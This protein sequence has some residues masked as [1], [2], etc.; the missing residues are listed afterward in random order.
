[1]QH[2]WQ[3]SEIIAEL[4]VNIM[5]YTITVKPYL[6][7]KS[8]IIINEQLA[9]KLNLKRKKHGYAA[10][11]IRKNYVDVVIKKYLPENVV[12]LSERVIEHLNMPLFPVFEIKT[13]G[14]EIGF[15]PCIGIL[16]GQKDE[17][18]TKRRLKKMTM[19]TLDYKRIHGAI[20]VFALDK[21]DKIKQLIEGYCYKHETDSWERGIFPYPSVIYRRTELNDEWK[22]YFLSVIGDTVFSNHSFDKWDMYKWFSSEPDINPHLPV[23]LVYKSNND[24]IEMLERYRVIYVKPISGMK[25]FGVVKVSKEEKTITFRYR[26]DDKNIELITSNKK[27]LEETIEKLFECKEYIIQQGLDLMNFDGGIVDFRCVMQKNEAC[28]WICNGMVARIGAKESVVSN[29]SSGGAALPADEVITEALAVSEKE[30]FEIKESVISLCVKVCRTLD[31]YGFNFGTL[32]LDIG[33]DKNKNIWL[34]EVNNRKPHPAIA[35]RANDI[36]SYYTILAC[37]LHYAKGLAGFGGKE[38][39]DCVL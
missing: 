34:I 25:G 38:V 32:G 27:E 10:F 17:E 8:L 39:K 24:V 12:M 36:R 11:G 28:M 9:E 33:I 5:N 16:C 2:T 3:V 37:P 18:I 15:G 4:E 13:R 19:N 1:M 7:K 31:E 14:N 22:N 23:T 35:L 21:V 30:A 26:K 20:I 6:S 29:I